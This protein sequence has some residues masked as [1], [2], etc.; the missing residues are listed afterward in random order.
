MKKIA[1]I[2]NSVSRVLNN[3][4]K[5]L[6]I[7]WSA[8]KNLTLLYYGI[9]GVI[10]FFPIVASF[11]YKLLIDYL[12]ESQGIEVTVPLILVAILGAREVIGITQGFFTGTLRNT[13]IDILFRNRFQ[14]ELNYR[15]YKKISHIDI[16]HLEDSDSQDLITKASD[17][18]TWRPPEF[19]RRFSYIF[20]NFVEYV[21]AFL[22]LLPFG[23]VIPVVLSIVTLPRLFL[24]TKYGKLQW[25][26][27][28]SGAPEV[29]KLW[30]FRW[31]LSDR[32]A[33]TEAKIFQ[34][35]NALLSQF[36]KIQ[37]YLYKINKK[38]LD[39]Y[40]KVVGL[41]QLIE[42]LAIFSF[43]YMKLPAV[44]SAGMSI[45]NFTFFL[46]MLD[47]VIRGASGLIVN[48]G[49]L[50]EHNL[51]VDHFLGVM[52][53]PK[54]IKEPD[55][56]LKVK[57]N[58]YPP[59]VEFRNVSFTYPGSTK[60]VIKNV[61]F[62]MNSHENVA[63]VG[64]NGAGKTTIVKLLC[65]FYDVSSGEILVNGVNIKK[66]DLSDWYKYLGTLFQ[67]FVH[68]NF[69]VRENIMLGNPK[70]KDE[71]L[72]IKAAKN[73]EASKFI[74]KL[75]N[76]YDQILGR[77]FKNGIDLSKGEWQKLAMARS[78]YEGAPI[79]ILDE[80]TS[81]IDAEAEY[82]I[83]RNLNKHYTDK[84][85]FLI[86][87]RFSTVRN[88]EKIIVLDKGKIV[89]EGSHSVLL[90]KDGIYARMFNKQALGYK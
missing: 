90:K 16:A 22:I 53:L 66:L 68:Y 57:K 72:M 25:S 30:Y 41:P 69:T 89:E 8:D 29:R 65:R 6:S 63:I 71:K 86:S 1:S 74:E 79:L 39:D 7:V 70:L 88:A 87:H 78:F 2:T 60:E 28:G 80:P 15:F 3:L 4:G 46:S 77:H 11:I 26:I 18:F 23:V 38:P 84:T 19:L 47:R 43:A 64:P 67:E 12:I 83:F 9:S 21:S 42:G 45:G 48:F 51:Y 10:A 27:Y 55:K 34:S 59:K 54:L 58:P 14:N 13:Y 73:S 50:Y 76:K 82:E 81:A 75:P 24:S 33:V 62:N 20:T 37:E 49:L 56:S 40:I 52:N 44:L 61:S 17:T 35:Q 5:M 32:V 36:K 85:L 31:L